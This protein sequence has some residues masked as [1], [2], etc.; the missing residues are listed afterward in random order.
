MSWAEV[1]KLKEKMTDLTD[2]TIRV[3]GGSQYANKRL[4]IKQFNTDFMVVTADGNGVIEV[5]VPPRNR[6]E[7]TVDDPA[8]SRTSGIFKVDVG[9]FKEIMFRKL[10]GDT[11]LPVNDFLIW[12]KCS[13][14]YADFGYQTLD[15]LLTDEAAITELM[16][17]NNACNYLIRSTQLAATVLTHEVL[18]NALALNKTFLKKI[19]I[20]PL[21]NTLIHDSIYGVNLLDSRVLPTLGGGT[22]SGGHVTDSK[23]NTYQLTHN[24]NV[25]SNNGEI[26]AL[27]DIT[28][29]TYYACHRGGGS[30][31]THQFTFIAPTVVKRIRH[32]IIG[33]L[34][35]GYASYNIKIYSSPDGTTWT[36]RQEHEY[37]SVQTWI[38][39]ERDLDINNNTAAKYWKIVIQTDD[40]GYYHDGTNW[41]RKDAYLDVRG[42]AVDA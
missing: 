30:I 27:T 8:D 21:W 17:D 12:T 5:A 16:S 14:E 18:A 31:W 22:A 9:E 29:T 42:I 36:L 39:R 6:Y 10:D 7:V 25:H 23:G 13:D 24:G 3:D 11:I 19:A 28:T 15:E 20:D 35:A 33:W 41:G 37:T 2:A 40:A 1:Q 4:V 32:Y 34:S 26:G 38:N